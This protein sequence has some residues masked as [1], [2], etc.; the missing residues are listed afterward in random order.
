MLS[1]LPIL[2]GRTMAARKTHSGERPMTEQN[3]Q[4]RQ[5]TLV[6]IGGKA[7]DV[8]V[9]DN[10]VTHTDGTSVTLVSVAGDGES[11]RADRNV[12]QSTSGLR[13]AAVD[14]FMKGAL[15]LARDSDLT[16]DQLNRLLAGAKSL[17]SADGAERTAARGMLSEFASRAGASAVG[18]L[19]AGFLESFGDE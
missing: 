11:I 1:F 4:T 15:E 2:S 8:S 10:V 13:A 18:R 12:L 3:P 9:T 16:P 5:V 19:I 7:K 14:R 6:Q 17:L